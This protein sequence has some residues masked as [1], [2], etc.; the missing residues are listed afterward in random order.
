VTLLLAVA[1]AVAGI[2]EPAQVPVAGVITGRVLM[3]G[4]AEGIPQVE[5]VLA[6]PLPQTAI[7][8]ATS[9]PLMIAEIAEGSSAP[10]IR[11]S[12]DESGSFV[13]RNLATGQYAVRAQREGYLGDISINTGSTMNVA[14]ATVSISAGSPTRDVR[15]ELIRGGTISGRVRDANGQPAPSRT[16]TAFQIGYDP[17]TGREVLVQAGSRTTDD[18]G[19]YRL[20]WL[21][22]GEYYVGVAGP[23][24]AGQL[25]L[26]LQ[27]NMI[28]RTF[29]P[30]VADA[31]SATLVTLAEGMELSGIDIDLRPTSTSKV[32]GRVVSELGEATPNTF[33]LYPSDPNALTE[34]GSRGVMSFTNQGPRPGLF[35]IQGVPPGSYDLV[36]SLPDSSRFPFPGRVRIDVASDDL[37]GV[38]LTIGAGVEVK[39]RVFL[40]GTL[41]PAMPLPPRNVSI[42]PVNP[43][44]A[45]S[46]TAPAPQA[47]TATIPPNVPR[48]AL[49]SKEPYGAPFDS[50]LTGT[51]TSDAAGTWIFPKVPAST[52]FVEVSG[53]PANAYISD[54]RAG[55]VGI[56]EAGLTISDRSPETIDVFLTSGALSISGVVR[57]L[58]GAPIR[59][60]TVALVPALERRQSPWLYKTGRTDAD[61]EF[62][63]SGV[64]PGEYKLFAWERMANAAY[65]NPAFLAKQEARGLSV[66]VVAGGNLD[67]EMTVIPSNDAP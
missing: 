23:F 9:N 40:D 38:T 25:A 19:E 58:P 67:F 49:R 4:S 3:A 41:V 31:R 18:R 56:G 48:I 34:A 33:Y 42:L 61:G 39:A 22:P 59:S 2:Q 44:T 14:S 13:F 21:V 10:L 29:Y 66:N 53:M 46:P 55:N 63:L 57:N 54:I 24:V 26:V 28:L 1:L 36:A 6:G 35:E 20:F 52:Y 5:I 43:P 17:R 64:A 7:N 60:A 8:A 32:S 62:S 27:T 11:T 65:R 16:V 30:N 15:F 51:V 45:G 12:T 37:A 50:Y 47:V